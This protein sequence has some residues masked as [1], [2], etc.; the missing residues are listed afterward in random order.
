MPFCCNG[1]AAN[2]IERFRIVSS[3]VPHRRG[4]GRSGAWSAPA[5]A[6]TRSWDL[7]PFQLF[8]PKVGGEII[9]H[10][11]RLVLRIAE[12]AEP[13]WSRLMRGWRTGRPKHLLVMTE[14]RHAAPE[15]LAS[16]R[17]AA[18]IAASIATKIR[19][20]EGPLCA[21]RQKNHHEA[22]PDPHHSQSHPIKHPSRPW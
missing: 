18:L 14:R 22:D 3:L 21:P 8:A 4:N 10:F 2:A 13:L 12:L 17:S 19:H 20:G 16:E 15:T 5:S 9:K 11:W 7:I 6:S 1:Q